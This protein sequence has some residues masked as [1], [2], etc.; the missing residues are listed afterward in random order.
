MIY[1]DIFLDI[2]D[3]DAEFVKEYP[4][5]GYWRKVFR[6]FDGNL[7]MKT[8]I[9]DVNSKTFHD[10]FYVDITDPSYKMQEELKSWFSDLLNAEDSGIKGILI[11]QI[12]VSYD[13]FA[14]DKPALEQIQNYVDSHFIVK[15]SRADAKSKRSSKNEDSTISRTDYMGWKGN[16]RKG[17]K[18]STG[19]IKKENGKEFFRYEMRFNRPNLKK[20]KIS[21]TM[22]PFKPQNFQVFNYIDILGDFSDNG[23]KNVARSIL[24]KKGIK[25]PSPDFNKLHRETASEVRGEILGGSRG[26]RRTVF[27]QVVEAKHLLKYYNMEINSKDYFPPLSF[28]YQLIHC[29]V[30]IGII[31]ENCSKRLMC[32]EIGTGPKCLK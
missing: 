11:N 22:M 30:D 3:L 10:R 18:G 26:P 24:R 9:Q 14:K 19:Y 29:L 15:Y 31:E 12:E 25:E 5:K 8:K 16:V 32:L 17:S 1:Y 13:F 28:L 2:L 21:Y 6:M 7:I 20:N 23:I 27:A 4:D